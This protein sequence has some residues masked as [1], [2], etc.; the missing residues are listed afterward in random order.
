MGERETTVRSS[1]LRALR[2]DDALR[3]GVGE[4]DDVPGDGP[5][6]GSSLSGA[7]L[8]GASPATLAT[9]PATSAVSAATM[10]RSTSKCS[11][12]S[13]QLL[14][15]DAST[16]ALAAAPMCLRSMPC[17]LR[18]WASFRTAVALRCRSRVQLHR[19]RRRKLDFSALVLSPSCELDLSLRVA[20]SALG[21]SPHVTAAMLVKSSLR[22]CIGVGSITRSATSSSSCGR[23][24]RVSRRRSRPM[25]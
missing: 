2:G 12:T 24:R 17:S 7:S 20:A 14:S 4:A 5:P 16:R 1:R 9:A 25:P 10:R 18:T 23:P 11:S 22:S 8:S 3:G 13:G 6:F 21:L 19:E 15:A